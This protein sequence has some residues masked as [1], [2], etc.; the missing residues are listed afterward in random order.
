MTAC[1]TADVKTSKTFFQAAGRLGTSLRVYRTWPTTTEGTPV[2]EG[3]P[4]EITT[5]VETEKTTE[6]E[7]HSSLATVHACTVSRGSIPGKIWMPTN[8]I[9]AISARAHVFRELGA[10][11]LQLSRSI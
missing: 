4:G 1:H 11:A 8:Q 9:R 10:R 2:A 5:P 6:T 3:L 7:A